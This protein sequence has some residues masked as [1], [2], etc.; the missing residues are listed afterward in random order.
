ML[1]N[2][3]SKWT[4]EESA[5][6]ER[7]LNLDIESLLELLPGRTK[8][9]IIAKRKRLLK[10]KEEAIP[11][12]IAKGIFRYYLDGEADGQ[13]LTRLSKAGYSYTLKDI[14][15]SIKSTR[16]EIEKAYAEE[17]NTQRKPTLDQ[18]KEFINGKTLD[19]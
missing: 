4:K 12:K 9:G 10:T 15:F 1:T 13:I 19:T 16:A 11:S 18:L 14:A 17:R 5:T 8:A 3:A 2:L 7:N 6:L